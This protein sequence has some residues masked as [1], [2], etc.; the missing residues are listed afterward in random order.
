MSCLLLF[1]AI[2]AVS[3]ALGDHHMKGPGRD[4]VSNVIHFA[5]EELKD[6]DTAL[7][8]A[9]DGVR[10]PCLTLFLIHFFI[11]NYISFRF[12]HGAIQSL[13]PLLNHLKEVPRVIFWMFSLLL[14]LSFSSIVPE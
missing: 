6:T 4:F 10:S 14:D 5:S 3:R 7:I 8:L 13:S 11:S 12:I 1:V 2:L 9:C